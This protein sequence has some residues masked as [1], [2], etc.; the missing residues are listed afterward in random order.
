[1]KIN[2]NIGTGNLSINLFFWHITLTL[3]IPLVTEIFTI[4]CAIACPFLRNTDEII[5]FKMAGLTQALIKNE[6]KIQINVELNGL[7]IIV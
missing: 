6:K 2:N 3:A 4:I 5:T 7:K 1:M